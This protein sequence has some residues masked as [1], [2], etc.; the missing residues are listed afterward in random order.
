MTSNEYRSTTQFESGHTRAQWVVIT[1]GIV[2]ALSII[3]IVSDFA[4][5]GLIQKAIR[6]ETITLAEALANDDR[7]ALIGFAQLALF[8][9]SGIAF[10]MWI[11][12]VHRNLPSLHVLG[13]RF[14]PGWAVGWFFVP[15]FSLFRPFQVVSEIWKASDPSIHKEDGTVWK[16]AAS[17]P[18]IGWWW[19]FFL[20][21]NFV[22]YIATRLGFQGEELADLLA[23]S[24]AYIASECIDIVGLVIAI[25]LVMAIDQRQERQYKLIAERA[26]SR[27]L[28]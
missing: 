28:D 11:H 17:S 20:I 24:Y 19:A 4:E 27:R 26:I 21:S 18:I 12:R 9:I 23:G 10:F 13:L 2:I 16:N 8:A 3:A 6:G 15:I 5:V 22:S 14:S 1:F 7:Q 25:S